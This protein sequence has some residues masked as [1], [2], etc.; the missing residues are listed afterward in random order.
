MIAFAEAREPGSFESGDVDGYVLSIA[1]PSNEAISS[2]VFFAGV[3]GDTSG[4]IIS[5]AILRRKGDPQSARRNVIVGAMV[6]A[7]IC[8]GL[9]FTTA[10]LT[11]DA[12]FL[13][14]GFF[15][16]E[17]VIGPIW[18]IPMDIAPQY[19]GTG[20]GLMNT[21]RGG[22]NR[23]AARLRLDRGS[24]R[25]LGIALRRVDSVVALG[26]RNGLHQAS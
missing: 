6:G 12:L 4:G 7:G 10:N 15:C 19:A 20:S 16:L 3:V 13:A 26:L 1:I 21:D 17:L 8:L 2:A 23:V 24:D 5:D 14:S 22:G 9:V 18:S 11:L 25:E